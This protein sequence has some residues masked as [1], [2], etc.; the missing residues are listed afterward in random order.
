MRARPQQHA[1]TRTRDERYLEGPAPLCHAIAA[2]RAAA[3]GY[4]SS[5]RR[6]AGALLGRLECRQRPAAGVPASSRPP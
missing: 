2:A 3:A 1:L 6:H 4:G 5:A